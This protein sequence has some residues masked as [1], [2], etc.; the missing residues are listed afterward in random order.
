MSPPKLDHPLK[1][2]RPARKP[3]KVGGLYLRNETVEILG[4]FP[5]GKQ[6][7]S[8]GIEREHDDNQRFF[9]WLGRLLG[10]FMADGGYN[11][12]VRRQRELLVRWEWEARLEAAEGLA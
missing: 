6:S 10:K 7:N 3:P 4:A 2:E 11:Q 5:C 9:R 1:I 12:L 8:L